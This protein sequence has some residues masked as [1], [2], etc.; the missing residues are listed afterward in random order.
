[1]SAAGAAVTLA[2]TAH[3]SYVVMPWERSA[4]NTLLRVFYLPAFYLGKLIWPASLTP[5]Y[6]LPSPF[7]L[8]NPTVAMAVGATCAAAAL[9]VLSLRWS[10]APV[11]GAL[12]ALLLI[13]PTLGV[14]GYTWV[15]ASDKYAYLPM[16]GLL[17]PLAG[18]L[19]WLREKLARRRGM[20][21]AVAVPVLVGLVVAG[22]EARA[23]RAQLALWSTTET[24]GRHV[25]RLAPESHQGYLLLAG[26]IV[27]PG[28]VQ[29]AIALYEQVIRLDPKEAVAHLA[30]AEILAGQNRTAEAIEHYHAAFA[31][32]PDDADKARAYRELGRE[33]S[34]KGLHEAAATMFRESLTIQPDA[35]TWNALGNALSNLKRP[36]EAAAAFSEAL[37]L[38]PDYPAA[39][40]NLGNAHFDLGRTQE[41]IASYRKALELKRDYALARANLADAL[42][43]A[44]AERLVPPAAGDEA[45]QHYREAVRLEPANAGFRVR[46][47]EALERRG[48]LPAA[49]AEYRQA[50]RLNPRHA[51]AAQKLEALSTLPAERGTRS[52]TTGPQ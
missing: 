12:A 46:L 11:V 9:V 37:R 35:G 50:L 7:S 2:S 52:E 33:F 47:G 13:S 45:L 24:L 44:A 27:D 20:G 48:D 17:L 32:Y 30:L 5:V 36:A 39:L 19:A 6:Q 16:I 43:K 49:A 51:R 38:Q 15:V 18:G 8:T 22:I 23:T 28:R 4:G 42:L 29:E 3:T 31:T 26:S 40:N 10:R 34:R 25:V 14:V 21:L 41:A 1:L